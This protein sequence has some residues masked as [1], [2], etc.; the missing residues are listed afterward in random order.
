VTHLDTSFVIDLLREKKRGKAGPAGALLATLEGEPLAISVFVLCELEAGAA[1]ADRS[2]R[3]RQRVYAL[4]SALSL[5]LPD[6]RLA[7]VYGDT[8]ARLLDAGRTIAAIDLLIASTALLDSAPIVTR[9]RKHFDI[10]P[11]LRVISY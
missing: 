3:E 5:V 4:C 6:E 10:V 9:N 2:E 11:K 1:R 8:L 7:A